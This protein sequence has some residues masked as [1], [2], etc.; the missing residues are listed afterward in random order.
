[1]ALPTG[2]HGEFWP[3]Y[4]KIAP[5]NHVLEFI[6]LKSICNGHEAPIFFPTFVIRTSSEVPKKISFHI[7]QKMAE[8]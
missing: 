6:D 4:P 7:S 8:I 5:K 2:L 3:P 1:V